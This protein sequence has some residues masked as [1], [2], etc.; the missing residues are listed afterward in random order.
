LTWCWYSLSGRFLLRVYPRKEACYI[1]LY[2]RKEPCL[3]LEDA[4]SSIL[5]LA[6]IPSSSSLNQHLKRVVGQES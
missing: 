3:L 2:L 5:P 1:N 6:E 4:I